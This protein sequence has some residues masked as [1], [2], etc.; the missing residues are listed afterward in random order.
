MTMYRQQG[1]YGRCRKVDKTCL[2]EIIH[3]LAKGNLLAVGQSLWSVWRWSHWSGQTATAV[4][5]TSWR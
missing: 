1:D 5:Q 2:L 3:V 4:G